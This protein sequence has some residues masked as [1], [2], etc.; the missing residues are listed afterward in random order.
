MK[1]IEKKVVPNETNAW[2]ALDK[3]AH[4]SA[5]IFAEK[6]KYFISKCKTEREVVNYLLKELEKEGFR[7]L[8]EIE[9][10]II[11]TKFYASTRGKILAIGVIGK[12][13]VFEGVRILAAHLDAPRIDLKAD[14]LYEDSG[15]ALFKT[16]YYGGIKKYQWTTIPLA[17]HGIVM[18]ADGSK[19][20]LVIGEDAKDPIFTITD[21]L[22][23]LA[24]E[25]MKLSLKEGIKGEEL[26]LLVGSLPMEVKKDEKEKVKAA[27]FDYLKINYKITKA[28]FISAE[29]EIV[30]AGEAR[31]V[32]FDRALIAGYGQDDRICVYATVRALLEAKQHDYTNIVYLTDKEEIGSTG[33]TGACS[34]YL[35]FV[36]ASLCEL[37]GETSAAAVLRTT[38]RSKALS[39]DVSAGFDPTFPNVHEK[40]N[41]AIINQGVVVEKYT[42]HGGKYEANDASAEYIGY[43]RDIF[44][45]AGIC[46]QTGELGKVDLGG[47][48]T[49]AMYLSNLGI[50][51]VDCGP[52]ML[53]MHAPQEISS[54]A[55]LYW[56]YLAYKAFLEN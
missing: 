35:E 43:V 9:E 45:R 54:K 25:Q 8:E 3:Q 29:L 47:G 23:H 42:G 22:P 28:D 34:R 1:K 19:I 27:I 18:L 31:D 5:I 51:T 50:E 15:L 14:P 6:Y 32:G 21:L 12:K 40:Q 17:L 11:G 13:K 30:P 36:L 56:T 53:S 39:A 7:P 38:Y 49:V 48:G 46:W 44:A 10:A 24:Q 4:E 33:D 20:E 41:A 16:H 37:Q 55:D 2:E 26:N 52:A